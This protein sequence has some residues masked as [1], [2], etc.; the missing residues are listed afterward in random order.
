[1]TRI[2]RASC[3]NSDGTGGL[4]DSAAMS[5]SAASLSCS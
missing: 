5:A 2:L 3:Q 4:P 1:M